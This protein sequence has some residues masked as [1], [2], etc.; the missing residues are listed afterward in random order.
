MANTEQVLQEIELALTLTTQLA[1]AF[2]AV[3]RKFAAMFDGPTIQPFLEELER[4]ETAMA[5]VK[6]QKAEYD[7]L[8]A[9]EK[10]QD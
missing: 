8:R 5:R 3:G 6:A 7:A 9:S 1:D 10:S 4:F 2:G